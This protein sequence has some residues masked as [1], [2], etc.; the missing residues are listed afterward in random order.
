M[1]DFVFQKLPKRILFA[2]DISGSMYTFNRIDQRLRRLQE[3][4]LFIME[5]FAGQEQ[6]YA[7]SMVGHSGTGPEAERLVPWGGP[8]PGPKEWESQTLSRILL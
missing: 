6:K 5:A 3:A 2:M 7:Y 4:A 1:E 8:P